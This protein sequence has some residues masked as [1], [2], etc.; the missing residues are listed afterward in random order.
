SPRPGAPA[1]GARAHHRHAST[2]QGSGDRHLAAGPDRVV[3]SAKDDA[4][5]ARALSRLLQRRSFARRQGCRGLC[6]EGAGSRRARRRG[7]N[8]GSHHRPFEKDLAEDRHPSRPPI[9]T[10]SQARSF[11]MERAYA[12][13]LG[14]GG[15]VILAV[16]LLA[17]PPLILFLPIAL[18]AMVILY[19]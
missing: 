5:G 10:G 17:A 18:A 13:P 19:W 12:R 16:V 8:R 3:A 1:S 2:H 7:R 4:S 14:I 6:A 11:L 9:R 15:L